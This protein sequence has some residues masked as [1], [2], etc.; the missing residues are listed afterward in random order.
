MLLYV[1]F[2]IEPGRL[3]R[4]I[5]AK[6]KNCFNSFCFGNMCKIRSG[7]VFISFKVRFSASH[8]RLVRT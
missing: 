8:R 7:A 1:S 2:Y 4:S 3:L 6:K 5:E